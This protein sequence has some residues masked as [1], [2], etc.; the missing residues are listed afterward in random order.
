MICPMKCEKCGM[1]AEFGSGK[2]NT[3]Q[4]KGG[5]TA[6]LCVSCITNSEGLMMMSPEWIEFIIAW[7]TFDT[8]PSEENGKR[9]I[10]AT[11][12]VRARG[13]AW[14]GRGA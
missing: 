2:V 3:T 5:V 8:T 12:A 6:N 14:L 7:R 11:V 1:S 4:M 13:L 10:A 9:Y